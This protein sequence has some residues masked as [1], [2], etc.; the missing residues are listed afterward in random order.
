MAA[1]SPLHYFCSST[2]QLSAAHVATP[3]NITIKEVNGIV[4]APTSITLH[5][6]GVPV[7]IAITPTEGA[8][9]QFQLLL[10]P[11]SDLYE[12]LTLNATVLGQ[13]RNDF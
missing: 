5:A 11:N 13:G 9:A 8:P 6:S 2:L 10:I 7:D 12:P 4:I 3:L 1:L